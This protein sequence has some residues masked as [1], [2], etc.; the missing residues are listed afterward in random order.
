MI[1]VGEESNNL[2]T[3]LIDIADGL[4]KRTARKLELL[5]QLL[6]PI[7]LLVMAGVTLLI[8]A[9]PAAAGVQDGEHGE[10]TRSRRFAIVSGCDELEFE[11]V[12]GVFGFQPERLGVLSPGQ[13]PGKR[14]N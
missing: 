2:E 4:E 11:R 13:R 3:V 12:E 5:V 14:C 8:V 9:G 7:M 10:L 6:E 1:T